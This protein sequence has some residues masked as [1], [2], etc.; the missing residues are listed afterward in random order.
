MHHLLTNPCDPRARRARLGAVVGL[1]ALLLAGCRPEPAAHTTDAAADNRHPI[2]VATVGLASATR[3]LRLPGVVR[4]AQRAEPA[5]LHPGHLAERFVARG[6][7]VVA[8]QR[9]ASLQNPALGP[10]LVVAEARVRELDERLLKFEADY[11]RARDLHAQ[12]LASAEMLDRTLA[13]RNATREARAQAVAGVTEARDQLADAILRA[14]FDATVSDLLVEPGDFVQPGQPV[15]V[16]AGDAGLEVEVQLPEGVA[17]KL[18]PGT[19]VEVRAV[20]SGRRIEG[21]IRE[22]GLARD[23]RPAP[24]IVELQGAEDWEPGISVHVAVTHADAAGL[25]VPLAA[26]VDPGTGQTRVFRV[27]DGRVELVSV[28]AGRLVGARVEVIGA[29]A[30]GDQVVVAGHQ[31]LLDG[32]SVKVLP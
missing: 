9:L 31:Q 13:E 7:R 27:A 23:G 11:Q 3:D 32:E 1:T 22:I 4:A 16:L 21:Q 14:P 30:A 10:G 29:L 17:R 26:I 12:G 20:G 19:P 28:T 8:G 25:T 15:M 5:F 24:A 2:K 18:T 6:D